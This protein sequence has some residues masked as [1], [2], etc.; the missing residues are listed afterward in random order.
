MRYLFQL[1]FSMQIPR[2]WFGLSIIN[3]WA[4]VAG[5]E[6]DIGRTKTNAFE[7]INLNTGKNESL[8]NLPAKTSWNHLIYINP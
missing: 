5:G 6:I 4:Y 1:T 3:G 7:R 2:L 8:A